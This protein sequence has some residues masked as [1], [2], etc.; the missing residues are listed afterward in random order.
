[1][2]QKMKKS[3][4]VDDMWR[5]VKEHAYDIVVENFRYFYEGKNIE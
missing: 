3:K 5:A 4:K 2:K 1:M